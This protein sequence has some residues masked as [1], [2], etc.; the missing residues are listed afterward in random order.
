[1]IIGQWDIKAA[2]TNK[3]VGFVNA[4]DTDGKVWREVF[5][6]KLPSRGYT[7]VDPGQFPIFTKDYSAIINQFKKENVEILTGAMIPPDFATFWKQAKQLGWQPKMV[8][9]A[10]PYLLPSDV[11]ALGADLANGLLSEVWWSPEYPWMSSLTGES[12][13]DIA[14]AWETETGQPWQQTLGFEHAGFELISDVLKRAQ[15]LEKEKLRDAIAETDLETVV[16]PIKFNEQHY[17][18]TPVVGGQ[19]VKN[20]AGRLELKIIYNAQNP[21]L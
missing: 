11:N 19:W 8:S 15:T 9:V 7:I 17:S 21:G 13:K 5:T 16:G 3:K 4:N 20:D 6:E 10:K 2:E 18:E 1:M 14:D 12:S